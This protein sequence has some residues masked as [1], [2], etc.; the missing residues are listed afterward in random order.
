MAQPPPLDP[1]WNLSEVSLLR[2]ILTNLNDWIA[3]GGGG[4]GTGLPDQ[5]GHAGEYLTTNGSAASWATIPAGG[6]SNAYAAATNNAGNTTITPSQSNQTTRL[7]FGG[8]ARS[9]IIILDVAGRSAGDK[10]FLDL[11]LPATA[12][13]VISVRNAT[14]GGTLLL[15]VESFP[16]QDLTTDGSLLSAHWEFTF[17]GT[18]WIYDMSNLPA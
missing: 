7:T 11:I 13:I 16:T 5:T 9:S 4:G 17:T 18:A 8:S 10:I 15:P 14:A 12:N 2:R 1:Y 3:N 6:A